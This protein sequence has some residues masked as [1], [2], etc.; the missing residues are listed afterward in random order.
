MNRAHQLIEAGI[1]EGFAGEYH[2]GKDA[3][4]FREREAANIKLLNQVVPEIAEAHKF[5]A[6]NVHFDDG[7]AATG[8]EYC[9]SGIFA[10][11]YKATYF[12]FAI[13]HGT[14]PLAVYVCEIPSHPESWA[15]HA[16]ARADKLGWIDLGMTAFVSPAGLD[17][18]PMFLEEEYV[19]F[20]RTIEFLRYAVDWLMFAIALLSAHGVTTELVVAP[21]RLNARRAKSA[22]PPLFEH[23]IVRIAG[24]PK[25]GS[26]LSD[27]QVRAS[28]RLHW[29]RGHLRS[30]VS[31]IRVL[32]RP[33]LVGNPQAGFVSH[34][35]L[36]KPPH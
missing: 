21:Q 2:P 18:Q 28:P 35:Y 6:T 31:G 34:D 11:P 30:M 15:I 7:L 29:R 24:T 36:L 27:E 19:D 1:V 13:D 33:C 16:F 3:E 9:T 5:D 26:E 23:R 25:D 10:P 17:I 8:W 12:D 14:M 22:K 4:G 20:Q 32:V